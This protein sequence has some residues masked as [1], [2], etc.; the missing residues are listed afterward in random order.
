MCSSESSVAMHRAGMEAG[1]SIYMPRIVR[2]IANGLS[3]ATGYGLMEEA[4]IDPQ[5]SSLFFYISF[6]L[7]YFLFSFSFQ[8]T[9]VLYSKEVR[10]R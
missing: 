4:S 10:G 7:F 9:P 8:R 6:L 2:R 1:L 5:F 3:T